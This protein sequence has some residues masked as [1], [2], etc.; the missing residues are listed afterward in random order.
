MN[1]NLA[2]ECVIYYHLF[3]DQSI[4]LST[5]FISTEKASVIINTR[6]WRNGNHEK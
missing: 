1:C 4:N 6:I 2:K 5:F 3:S